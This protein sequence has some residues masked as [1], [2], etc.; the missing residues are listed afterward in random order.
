MFYETGCNSVETDTD[1]CT[2]RTII[3]LSLQIEYN[4]CIHLVQRV[5]QKVGYDPNK[6]IFVPVSAMKGDNLTTPTTNMAWYDNWET[7]SRPGKHVTGVTLLDALHKTQQP[8]RMN[9]KSLRV[10]IH[11]VYKLGSMSNIS[12]S[13]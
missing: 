10:P 3:N 13:S 2:R 1:S 11:A 6:V 12:N 5:A 9:S 4:S 8:T 7:V